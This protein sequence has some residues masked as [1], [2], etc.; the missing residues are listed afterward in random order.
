MSAIQ[1]LI[2]VVMSGIIAVYALVVAVLI[3]GNM[4]PPP[5][6]TYSLYEGFMHL[7]CGL[8]VGLTGLAAGYAIGIVGD[9][10]CCSGF[11]MGLEV[12]Q[13][14]WEKRRGWSVGWKR[15][16]VIQLFETVVRSKRRIFGLWFAL[17]RINSNLNLI[18]NGYLA[19][20]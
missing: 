15:R 13:Q 14:I 8:S 12:P 10:V 6:Q 17:S 16:S 2:P 7:A 20:L 3:A 18:S 1:S 19:A 11:V 4:K 9:T 5:Q